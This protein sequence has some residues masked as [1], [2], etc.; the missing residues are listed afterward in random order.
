MLFKRVLMSCLE[1]W[2]GGWP[3]GPFGYATVTWLFC[4]H[5]CFIVLLFF[6]KLKRR[7]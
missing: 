5:Y 6:D 7:Q 4:L 2:G 1:D 3:S